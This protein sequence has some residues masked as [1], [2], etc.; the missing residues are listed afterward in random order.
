MINFSQ[1]LKESALQKRLEVKRIEHS[2][3]KGGVKDIRNSINFL[4]QMVRMFEGHSD[5][6]MRLNKVYDDGVPIVCG[7]HPETGQ[8]FVGSENFASGQICY[9][10]ADIE[11]FFG[12]D[13][14]ESKLYSIALRYV[15]Y[16]EIQ[17]II[18]GTILFINE[19]LKTQKIGDSS[20]VTFQPS[21]R[22]YAVPE[23]TNLAKRIKAAR[24]GIVWNYSYVGPHL[25]DLEI[26]PNVDFG[27]MVT[28]RDVWSKDGSFYDLSGT[29]TWTKTESDRVTNIVNNIDMLFA[30]ISPRVLNVLAINQLLSGYV[31]DFIKM[32][33]QPKL[34]AKSSRAVTELIKVI[35][36]K[37]NNELIGTKHQDARLNR[38]AEKK[39]V[40][41][42][43][44][45]NRIHLSRMF[46][47]YSE[48]VSLKGMILAKLSEAEGTGFFINTSDG[49]KVVDDGYIAIDNIGNIVKLVDRLTI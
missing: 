43:F 45:K 38:F 12:T 21:G 4:K 7:R 40:L 5:T 8:F 36:G 35:E 24:I 34:M 18:K 1:F 46:D 25:Y 30:S 29:A 9:T 26:S 42:F 44:N 41:S 31:E 6:K 14:R 37:F 27:N 17:S 20:Y 11:K 16:L 33:D 32:T 23:D 48:I 19:D 13:T 22:I 3:F 49:L 28:T 2:V 47:L 15:A 39:I 10:Y